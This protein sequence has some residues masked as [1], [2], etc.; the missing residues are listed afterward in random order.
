MTR[1]R[2]E[3]TVTVSLYLLHVSACLSIHKAERSALTFKSAHGGSACESFEL[4]TRAEWGARPPRS[5]SYI[6]SVLNMTFVHHTAGEW[7]C[8]DKP[9]CIAQVQDIQR[10]H[11]DV[12]GW[13]DIGYSYLIGEDG[14]VYEGRGWGVV[15][16]HTLNYNSIAY[17]FCIIG[18]FMDRQPNQQALAA[19]QNI[20]ECGVE[21]GYLL[22]DYE[23]FGHRDGVCTLCP[24]DFLYV[25]IRGWPHYSFRPIPIYC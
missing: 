20:I 17:G 7:I 2:N 23:T 21:K 8:Y 4:V 1:L 13:A 18:N 5:I 12:N 11:M 6:Q 16:A 22:A 9:Q 24:G 10:L 14:R 3:V 25:I 15:G 19:A